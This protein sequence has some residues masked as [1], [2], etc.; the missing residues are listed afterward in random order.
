V[1]VDQLIT[2]VL[3]AG[4]FDSADTD[5]TSAR[6]RQALTNTL[7]TR[8]GG[9]VTASRSGYWLHTQDQTLSADQSSYRLPHRAAAIE[10]IE[11]LDAGDAAY[12]VIGDRVQFDEDNPPSSGTLRVTY[13]LRPS[14][15]VQEQ[16]VNIGRVTAVDVDALTVMVASVP[17]VDRVE[18]VSIVSGDIVDIVHKNGWHELSLVGYASNAPTLSST[19]FTFPAGTDLSAVEVND[20]VR[21][22]DQ[23]EWPCIQDEYH[24]VLAEL[25]AAD[26]LYSRNQRDKADALV[27]KAMG[28]DRDPGPL[29]L[30]VDQ[31]EPRVKA[32]RQVLVP[33]YGVGR[34]SG[35]RWPAATL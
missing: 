26:M 29:K 10:S 35:R 3:L 19:T 7:H 16:T 27:A 9:K 17:I 13:Y 20:Y 2:E 21:A 34:R 8:F 33:T 15:L 5:F 28:T 4:R 24:P 18:A 14:L 1:R 12:N 30:F 6:I 25:T 31:I 11:I 32:E 23:T 22:A